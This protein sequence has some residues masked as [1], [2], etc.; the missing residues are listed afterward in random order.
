M[1]VAV[2]FASSAPAAA[3]DFPLTVEGYVYDPVGSLVEGATVTITIVETSKVRVTTTDSAGYYTTSLDE[4]AASEYNLGDTIRVVASKNSEIE[5]NET[6]V[7]QVTVDSGSAE[8][9]VHFIYA[10]PEFG[11]LTGT[12]VAMSAIALVGAAL[13]AR[14]RK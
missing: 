1:L 5:Q 7:D 12:V 4:F 10:I 14:R 6:V 13:F 9:D 2:L 3:A 11:S 8:V